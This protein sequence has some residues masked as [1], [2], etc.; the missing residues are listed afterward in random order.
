MA[1]PQRPSGLIGNKGIELLTAGT[2][3]GFKIS[4]L[5][6]ELKEAYGKKYTYQNLD[7]VK[8]NDQKEP[9]FIKVGPNGRIPVII[10]HDKGGYAVMETLAIL[11]YLAHH[12]DTDH[13]FS[14]EDPLDICTAEQW[15]AWQHAGL[16]PMQAQAN[17]YYRFCPERHAFPTQRFFG[18]TERLYGVLEARLANRDYIAGPGRGSYSIVDIAVWPFINSSPATGIDLEKFP[19][20]YG[21]W[22]R[23][24]ERPAV[25][26]GMMVPSGREFPYGYRAVQQ[27]VKE[28]PQGAEQSEGQ[29]RDALVR[30]QQQVNY[31]Y[32]SP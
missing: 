9:W 29:L 7:I 8:Y 2:P 1:T 25:K 22:E 17:F 11:N 23:I 31:V 21:W 30:A 26:S 32:Q 10:D 28:D 19:H 3:N 16:G 12:Y 20:I 4:I 24:E 15:M 6:E 14:F 13:K 18:E 5:L 27:R